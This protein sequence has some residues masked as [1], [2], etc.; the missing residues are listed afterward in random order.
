M[1]YE[2]SGGQISEV[3]FC[4][5]KNL[6]SKANLSSWSTTDAGSIARRLK[7]GTKSD[8]IEVKKGKPK[9]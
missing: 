8:M 2:S 5:Q 1:P 4:L 3:R 9:K 7:M 6:V